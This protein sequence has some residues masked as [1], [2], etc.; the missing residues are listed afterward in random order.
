M[1]TEPMVFDPAH[2]SN[3]EIVELF[4]MQTLLGTWRFDASGEIKL[5]SSNICRILDFPADGDVASLDVIM[6]NVH[7]D[8][9]AMVYDCFAQA[10]ASGSS[11]ECLYRVVRPEGHTKKVRSVGR[12]RVGAN[13]VREI[14]GVTYEVHEAI[15]SIGYVE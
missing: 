9:H 12:V 3:D 7:P 13:G 1:Q 2:F 5:I 11:L 6:K 14:F 8:D 15:R 10:M 4:S